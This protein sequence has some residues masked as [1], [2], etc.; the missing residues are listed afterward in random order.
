MFYENHKL[1]LQLLDVYH[2]NRAA[3]H[4]N[5]KKRDFTGLAY[6]L[7]GSSEF[8]TEKQTVSAPQG[9]L[10]YIPQYL[11]FERVSTD[12]E[13]IIIHFKCHGKDEDRLQ[14]IKDAKKQ[15]YGESI[16]KINEEWESKA[17]GYK[18]RC[19]SLLYSLFSDMESNN[20]PDDLTDEEAI[21][22]QSVN[23][24]NTYYDKADI[25]LSEIARQS[26]ISE[27]Y[28]R[29]I[30]KKLYAITPKSAI[31]NK[32]IKKACQMLKTGYFSVEETALKVGYKDVKYFSTLFL[33][34]MNKT[35]SEYKNSF[36]TI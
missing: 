25:S 30:Y 19:L 5:I 1:C 3:R 13:L 24:L 9:S 36:E 34:K 17:P 16:L 35:P 21:I 29:K 27:V 7:R 33:K 4:S 15:L 20:K 22:R 11:A 10:I 14:V 18:N 28:F 6:R 8:R 23:Y 26:H 31:Q 12:E 2:I 32:R